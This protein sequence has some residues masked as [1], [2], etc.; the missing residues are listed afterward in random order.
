MRGE[1]GGGKARKPR[2]RWGGGRNAHSTRWGA[3]TPAWRR[4]ERR[5]GGEAGGDGGRRRGMADASDRLLPCAGGGGGGGL[6]GWRRAR[7]RWRRAVGRGGG[8][9]GGRRGGCGGGGGGIGG[10]GSGGGARRGGGCGREPSRARGGRRRAPAAP[11]PPPPPQPRRAARCAGGGGGAHPRALAPLHAHTTPP[12]R[13][14][15]KGPGRRHLAGRRVNGARGE[16][17]GARP[18]GLAWGVFLGRGVWPNGGPTK[19]RSTRHTICPCTWLTGW[20][21]RC[22]TAVGG[23]G[24]GRG[25]W[26][27]QPT[28]PGRPNQKPVDRC[29]RYIC[30]QG[31]WGP[32]RA[33]ATRGQRAGHWRG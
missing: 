12:A 9:R 13:C 33:A 24:G 31:L 1:A 20:R 7:R 11:P 17:G 8:G 18:R 29:P 28:Q 3:A 21:L 14:G 30:S 2:V 27:G 23:W 10:G 4:E 16:E 15:G 5:G 25:G 19:K 6:S 26:P 22:T 32:A